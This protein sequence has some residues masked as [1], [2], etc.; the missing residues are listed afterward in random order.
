M[1]KNQITKNIKE[2]LRILRWWFGTYALLKYSF[3]FLFLYASRLKYFLKKFL[4]SGVSLTR[5]RATHPKALYAY[6]GFS[7][8]LDAM[9][10]HVSGK[11]LA[12]SAIFNTVRRLISLSLR[13]LSHMYCTTYCCVC[14]GNAYVFSIPSFT[15]CCIRNSFS[16]NVSMVRSM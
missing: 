14:S 7:T 6:T 2:V 1:A 11:A 3:S 15:I 8:V 13:L 10:F 12:K 16:R 5:A 9:S 4:G